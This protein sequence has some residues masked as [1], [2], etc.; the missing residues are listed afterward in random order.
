MKRIHTAI[1]AIALVAISCQT[2]DIGTSNPA[3]EAG[4]QEIA[5]PDQDSGFITA[6]VDGQEV[7]GRPVISS[8][9]KK[10][11]AIGAD[12][13]F[14]YSL[15]PQKAVFEPGDTTPVSKSVITSVA[16]RK[17]PNNTVYYTVDP[18]LPRK[19]RVTDAIAHWESKTAIRFVQR[20]NQ[21]NYV[22][23]RKGSGCSSRVGMSGGR[24]DINLADG[25]STGNNIHE[26]GHAIGLMHEQTREDRD[27]HVNI[28]FNNIQKG[29]E[30]NFRKATPQY[31]ADHGPFDF[32]SIMMYGAYSFAINRG[33]PTITKKNGD[34][35]STQRKGLSP[36]DIASVASVYKPTTTTNPTPTPT[37]TPAPTPTYVNG[38]SYVIYGVQVSRYFDK[39]WYYN[40]RR[41][42]SNNGWHVVELREKR[43]Y[44]AR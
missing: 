32:N 40:P 2:E 36:G 27:N 29:F 44:Y 10:L 4:S 26:I 9:G 24:Q 16:S 37:P 19:D 14:E 5:F 23:F 20:T 3:T 42:N 6:Y 39:W 35:F 15:T 28:N 11:L 21:K 18:N 8:S 34:T 43:W 31:Y 25:C 33:T 12:Q 13:L 22:Y 30:G 38:Q 17:W 41:A 1:A 7:Y